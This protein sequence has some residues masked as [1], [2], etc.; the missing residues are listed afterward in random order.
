MNHKVKPLKLESID[1]GGGQDDAFPT[2]LNPQ[3]DF[4]EVRGLILDDA[5]NTDETTVLD[6]AGDNMRFMDVNNATPLTLSQLIALPAHSITD[7]SDVS[8]AT[9]AQLETLTGG[10]DVGALHTHAAAYAAIGHTIASHDTTATGAQLNT[11][12]GGGGTTLHSHTHA[13][14]TGKG[15]DDHHAQSHSIVSHSDTTATGAELNTLTAGASSDAQ[16][17]HTH[18]DKSETSH[19]HTHAS[20]TGRTTDDHHA[21]SHSIASHSDTTA[22]GAQLN[23]LTAGASSDAQSLHTHDDKSE[24]NHTHTHASTTGRGTDDHHAQTHTLGSHSDFSTYLN[25]AVLTT[26]SPTFVEPHFSA[27]EQLVAAYDGDDISDS[28]NHTVFFKINTGAV[29]DT[30]WHKLARIKF[31]GAWS[32]AN[33]RGSL[34]LGTSYRYNSVEYFEVAALNGG[35]ALDPPTLSYVKWGKTGYDWLQVYLVTDFDGSDHYAYDIYVALP[36]WYRGIL[37]TVEITGTGGAPITVWQTG[38]DTGNVEPTDA[39]QTASG[40]REFFENTYLKVPR[41]YLGSYYL[42]S[43][44][45]VANNKVLDSDKLDGQHGSYYSIDGHVHTHVSTT[46]RGTDDHHAQSHNIASHSD[47]SATGTELN[48]L[49]AGASSDAQ[50]LHTHNDK[51]ETSHTHTHAST[52][53]RGTDDHHAQSHSIAS[54]DTTATGAQLNTLIGGGGTTLHSHSHAN[55]TGKG[56]DDHHPQAHTH[57]HVSTTGRGTDDHHAQ[58]HNIASHSDTSATGAELNTLTGGAASDAQNLHTHNDKSETSHVH[59]HASTTGRGT[60]DHHPQAHSHTHASTTGRGTDDHHAQSHTI[61]SHS[62]TTATG[63]QL[64]T[65]TAGAAS[66]A[67][68]LHTHDDKS[69]TSHTHTHVSTTGRGTDDHHA[70]SHNIASHSDTSA[71]GAELNTLTGG[72]GTTLHSHAH[73]DTTGRGTDDH[74]AQSHSIASHSD[75]TATGAELN[76]LTGGGSTTLHYHS[77]NAAYDGGRTITADAGEIV[78]N[79]SGNTGGLIINQGGSAGSGLSVISTGSG[80]HSISATLGGTSGGY[81]FVG[82]LSSSNVS[83]NGIK[84]WESSGVARTGPLIEFKR[85]NTSATLTGHVL[86]LDNDGDGNALDINVTSTSAG[87]PIHLANAGTAA[88]IG[89]T[90]L[91]SDPASPADADFWYNT[92]DDC[93]RFYDGTNTHSLAAEWISVYYNTAATAQ[94]GEFAAFNTSSYGGAVVILT[95]QSLTYSSGNGRFTAPHAGTYEVTVTLFLKQSASGILNKMH[96]K[97]NGSTTLWS[98]QTFVDYRTDPHEQTIAII[99]DLAAGNYLEVILDSTST[100]NLTVERGSTFSMRRIG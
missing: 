55:T 21:Q 81:I 66:D 76:T 26:S 90:P 32:G 63:A 40:T 14:A 16:S 46:G 29:D 43:S 4:I 70:Q 74:H 25:Q 17:L 35:S 49:T 57:T 71:T 69:E 72:G 12:I 64:N 92:T 34:W 41:L 60:D 94:T 78:I 7:H 91:S 93:L 24:T 45:I 47:T 23:T 19:T 87:R 36:T 22:T 59:T 33:F 20:T 75:T 77:L 39:L 28:V 1:T 6:R 37:G 10:G 80:D 67:Q 95:S 82:Y 15:T 13:N 85:E 38:D 89:L 18:D 44:G 58:S 68:S 30:H 83:A 73:S 31:T 84:I 53:G 97:K 86:Y 61:A 5:S 99:V 88:D 79:S 3:E 50:S 65:L 8:D 56:T 96:I 48:T 51:S 62:D 11:L 54:H 52:T 27:I 42:D 2:S 100:N 9:G 98:C